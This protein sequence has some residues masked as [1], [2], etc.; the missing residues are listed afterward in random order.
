VD[1][2]GGNAARIESSDAYEEANTNSQELYKENRAASADIFNH[3]PMR[4]YFEETI[5]FY[6]RKLFCQK[7]SK[8]YLDTEI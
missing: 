5:N 6:H 4:N 8:D 7:T 2:Y 3:K 1:S